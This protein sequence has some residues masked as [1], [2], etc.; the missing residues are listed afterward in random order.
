MSASAILS[1]VTVPL[2]GQSGGGA[3]DASASSGDFAA[4]L[5]AESP[6]TPASPQG[7]SLNVPETT[8][9]P[10]SEQQVA[11]NDG[12]PEDVAAASA[13]L[14]APLWIQL[15]SVTVPNGTGGTDQQVTSDTAVK[16]STDGVG[17][18]TF[19][20]QDLAVGPETTTDEPVLPPVPGKDADAR[21]AVVAEQAKATALASAVE[22]A[23][24]RSSTP[25]GDAALASLRALPGAAALQQATIT[26]R[27]VDVASNG[28]ASADALAEKD[29]SASAGAKISD[30][31][32]APDADLAG[33]K[34]SQPVDR[35]AL[36]SSA[37]MP[38]AAGIVLADA[39]SSTEPLPAFADIAQVLTDTDAPTPSGAASASA[40]TPLVFAST[41][42]LSLSSLSRATIETTAQLAAQITHR[43]AGQSTRFEL[44]LTPEGLGRVDVTLDIDS[45]GQLSARLAFDN[46]LAATE[47]RG[48]ADDL[49]R[50]LEDAGFTVARDALEFS[51]RDSSS[52]G[53]TDRRQQRATAYA[54]RHAAQTDLVDAPPA[55]T[56][57]SSSLTPRGVDVKV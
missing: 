52:G 30:G 2:S 18:Q 45:D 37:G 34:A 48:R 4:V 17:L 7:G 53:G 21:S 36:T 13:A 8:A 23:A 19:P 16:P 20:A 46:P 41:E 5:A 22:V 40:S 9:L 38:N 54:D 14:L 1:P 42:T 47:L 49:R 15:S 12:A 25:A 29:L 10:I 44:G 50:Q 31:S 32:L 3:A 27:K 11:D 57:P 26:Q 39:G 28:S 24:Q 51:S 6:E 55:W 33:N 56:L 35:S 43:L